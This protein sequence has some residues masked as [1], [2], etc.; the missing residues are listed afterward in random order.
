MGASS[1]NNNSQ[2]DDDDNNNS[3][4]T[5]YYFGQYKFYPHLQRFYQTTL[6]HVL[7]VEPDILI[8]NF[9]LH[10]SWRDSARFEKAMWVLLEGIQKHLVGRIPLIMYRENSVQHFKTSYGEF[11]L[12]RVGL[13][14]DRPGRCGPL[15]SR[16]GNV[17]YQWRDQRLRQW[18]LDQGIDVVQLDLA[19]PQPNGTMESRGAVVH[20]SKNNTTKEIVWLPF[21]NT[22]APHHTLHP[23]ECTHYCH[24]PFLWYPL[25]RGIRI[26]SEWKFGGTADDTTTAETS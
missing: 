23:E 12:P 6:Q 11:G 16:G 2:G 26:A 10:Y 3:L 9:G 7:E 8:L 15:A 18:A 5:L 21:A 24:T 25:W 22:T 13:H 20:R 1:K 14:G 19:P 17:I 4:L